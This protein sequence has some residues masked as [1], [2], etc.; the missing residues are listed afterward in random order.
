[1]SLIDEALRRAQSARRGGEPNSP[2]PWTAA[3]LPDSRRAQ[4]RLWQAGAV[5]IAAIIG[6]AGFALLRGGHAARAPDART[7]AAAG[8][9]QQGSPP[10]PPRQ[11]R[12]I[13]APVATNGTGDRAAGS[14]TIPTHA[15][16]PIPAAS[17]AARPAEPGLA[18]SSKGPEPVAPRQSAIRSAPA[19]LLK[20]AS[21]SPRIS[22]PVAAASAPSARVHTPTVPERG[23]GVAEAAVPGGHIELGGIVYSD[24]NPVAILN[25]RI[26][27]VGAV[28]DGF[29]VVSIEE[30]RVELKSEHRTIVLTLR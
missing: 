5:L 22:A 24:T 19:A 3:P 26:M 9:R 10:S 17:I 25:G 28:V 18:A 8:F 2:D 6:A 12:Q 20:S 11:S 23:H 21:S 13:A 7:Q 30:N 15:L 14:P 4:R 27:G 16:S 29:T 1:V